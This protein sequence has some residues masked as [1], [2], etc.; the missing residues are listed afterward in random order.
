MPNNT[1]QF[2]TQSDRTMGNAYCGPKQWLNSIDDCSGMIDKAKLEK[3]FNERCMNQKNCTF[4]LNDPEIVS[5]N[6]L[7]NSLNI[8][9][10]NMVQTQIWM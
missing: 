2:K 6:N 5:H 8:T 1:G 4:D 9:N 7:G 3:K 10:C